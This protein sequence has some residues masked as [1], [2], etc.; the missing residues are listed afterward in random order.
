MTRWTATSPASRCAAS[1]SAAV[2]CDVLLINGRA[3]QIIGKLYL[4][5]DLERPVSKFHGRTIE[6]TTDKPENPVVRIQISDY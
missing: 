5:G 6:V 1:L 4:P 3:G 2:P